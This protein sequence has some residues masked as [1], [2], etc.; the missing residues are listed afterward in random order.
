MRVSASGVLSF[1]DAR[2]QRKH[3]EKEDLAYLK[4]G[5]VVSVELKAGAWEL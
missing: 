4:L 3:G 2:L 5:G 1:F